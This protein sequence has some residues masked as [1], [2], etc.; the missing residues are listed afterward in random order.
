MK[1]LKEKEYLAW[2]NNLSQEWKQIFKSKIR[3]T[4]SG[5]NLQDVKSLFEIKKLEA[6]GTQIKSLEP[7]KA[8]EEQISK[9]LLTKEQR[10]FNSIIVGVYNGLP[11]WVEFDISAKI[12][13]L[14]IKT[15]KN[16]NESMGLLIFHGDEKMFAIDGQRRVAGIDIANKNDK[17][18]ILKEDNFPVIFLAHIDNT[19]G[20][21]RTRRL[22]SDI[23]KNTKP[24][25]E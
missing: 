2:W 24:K 25:P 17:K 21:K 10:F 13:K 23:N 20:R 9:Y 11:D 4:T 1:I 12:K 16:I 18:K 14:N 19:K 7:I 22:F 3:V 5:V 8:K 6:G 15:A